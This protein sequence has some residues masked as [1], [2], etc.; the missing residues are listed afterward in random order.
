ML[1]LLKCSSGVAGPIYLLH[2]SYGNLH[3]GHASYA[4]YGVAAGGTGPACHWLGISV[5]ARDDVWGR[6]R[7]DQLRG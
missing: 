5:W 2:M 3:M 6:A 4:C 7:F 1:R